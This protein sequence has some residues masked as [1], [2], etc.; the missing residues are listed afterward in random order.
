MKKL[1]CGY[2]D[3]YLIHWPG[4]FGVNASNAENSRKRA[5][6]WKQMIKGVKNGLTRNIGVSNY[7]VHHLTELLQI[8]LGKPAVNQVSKIIDFL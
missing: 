8:G 3:L 2:I 4:V 7:N 1:D 5:E 6:S